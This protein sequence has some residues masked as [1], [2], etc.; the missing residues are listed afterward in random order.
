[1]RDGRLRIY[2]PAARQESRLKQKGVVVS[3][4]SENC[5]AQKYRLYINAENWTNCA[6]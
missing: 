6:V 4:T 5:I 3:R 1:M 2:R